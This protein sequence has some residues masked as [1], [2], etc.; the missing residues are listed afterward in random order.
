MTVTAASATPVAQATVN[1]HNFTI[2]GADS[3]QS[4]NTDGNGV[5]NFPNVTLRTKTATQRIITGTG[6]DREGETITVVTP[7]KL[8]VSKDG[9]DTVNMNLL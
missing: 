4:H 7:P 9:Y 6:R 1:L 2:N 8:T 5:A 3:V